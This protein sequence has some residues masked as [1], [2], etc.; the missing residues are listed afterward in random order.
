MKNEQTLIA[1]LTKL[2]SF[3]RPYFKK[4]P[5][6]TLKCSR[7]QRWADLIRWLQI[8]SLL[9]LGTR[10]SNG[11]AY[12]PYFTKHTPDVTAITIFT[13]NL[14]GIIFPYAEYVCINTVK[15]LI[16]PLFLLNKKRILIT[17]WNKS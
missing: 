4:I 1:D 5:D 8:M 3:P 10:A 17:N 6:F 2:I 9:F 7:L 14:A 15:L 12:L 16:I 11:A 13:T